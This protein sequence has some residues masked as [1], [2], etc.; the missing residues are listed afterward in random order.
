MK[1]LAVISLVLATWGMALAGGSHGHGKGERTSFIEKHDADGNGLVSFEEFSEYFKTHFEEMDS[2]G[3]GVISEDEVQA[4]HETRMATRHK[5]MQAHI[6][7][8]LAIH[9]DA[10]SSGTVTGDEWTTFINSL[11]TD[12]TGAIDF[13]T[14][15]NENKPNIA[16]Q[17]AR[18]HGKRTPPIAD[19]NENGV[20]DVEDLQFLFQ[21]LDADQNGVLENGE[22]SRRRWNKGKRR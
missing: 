2:N 7:G 19:Q 18:K 10:D 15:A 13:S 17:M 3:D 6:G 11:E 16:R 20:V 14:L 12:E 1:Y 9:A 21:E 8:A 5:R 4:L 22:I